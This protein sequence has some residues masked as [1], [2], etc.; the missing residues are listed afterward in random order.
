M[1]SEDRELPVLPATSAAPASKAVI[2]CPKDGIVQA[3]RTCPKCGGKTYDMTT[4]DGW[5]MVRDLR[6]LH[7]S[8]RARNAQTL[9]VAVSVTCM[10]ALGLLLRLGGMFLGVALLIGF[11]VGKTVA[12][13]LDAMRARSQSSAVRELDRILSKSFGY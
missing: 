2:A 8:A 1:Q 10:L 11:V 7:T 12:P 5:S 13:A 9:A 6:R 3:G 4:E